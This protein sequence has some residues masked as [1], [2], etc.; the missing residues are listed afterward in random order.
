MPHTIR[1][2]IDLTCLDKLYPIGFFSFYIISFVFPYALIAKSAFLVIITFCYAFALM[3]TGL[4]IKQGLLLPF[5]TTCL[6]SIF[7]LIY[8]FIE[9][10]IYGILNVEFWFFISWVLMFFSSYRLI[11]KGNIG[12]LNVFFLCFLCFQIFLV[13]GQVS[14]KVTGFGFYTLSEFS[15]SANYQYSNML[16]GSF[17]NSNDLASVCVMIALFFMLNRERSE[18]FYGIS[19]FLSFLL[20]LATMSRVSF[21]AFLLVYLYFEARR[22]FCKLIF[23][24]F[25]FILLAVVFYYCANEVYGKYLPLDRIVDRINSIAS[26][27]SGGVSNDNSISLRLHSYL[28]FFSVFEELGFG[29]VRYQDYSQFFDSSEHSIGLFA[30]NPHSFVFEVGYWL[31]WPGLIIL[32]GFFLS[33]IN[34]ERFFDSVCVIVSFILISCVSS[35]I[36]GGFAFMFAFFSCALSVATTRKKGQHTY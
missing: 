23:A 2:Q 36:V 18:R 25:A 14:M 16:S 30:T 7:A 31:G 10:G 32:L 21:I 28:N 1:F 9:S 27:A 17:V 29:S 35:S 20:I 15:E 19:V 26:V 12:Y 13:L 5:L 24:T 6:V 34:L 3:F 22:S 33:F 11:S 4:R 8:I